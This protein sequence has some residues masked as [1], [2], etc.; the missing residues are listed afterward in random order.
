MSWTGFQ[1]KDFDV[2]SIPGLEPRMEALKEQIR[3]KLESL[4]E[5]LR[6][7]LSDLAG[8]Q[9]F[10]HVAKHA[11][12]TVN[13]P[14]ETWVAWSTQKR[15]YKAHPHFQVG[16][17]KPHL[18]AMFAL[19]YESPNKPDFARN[20]LEQMDELLPFIPSSFVVSQDHTRPEATPV[21]ELGRTGMEKVLKRLQNV[22]KAEF[23]CGIRL[24]RNH[25]AVQ[26]ADRLESEIK[27]AFQTLSPLYRLAVLSG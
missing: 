21:G 5:N 27:Q 12:R 7:D 9:M 14:D 11:R 20:F 1:D 23:L 3:P 22:K 13:P 6:P 8:E 16:M 26:E 2:F 19:I 15:G 4:G 24:D 25:P 10:V 18:F 17:R